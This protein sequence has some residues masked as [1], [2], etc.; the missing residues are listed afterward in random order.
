MSGF[1][2]HEPYS[3][4]TSVIILM[5]RRITKQI[6]K[7]K[8]KKQENVSKNAFVPLV[9]SLASGTNNFV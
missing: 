4:K 5:Y 3:K 8:K 7:R 9:C 1:I 6:F 2:C